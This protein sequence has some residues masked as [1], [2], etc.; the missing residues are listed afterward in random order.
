MSFTGTH[1]SHSFHVLSVAS[2]ALQQCGRAVV[3]ETASQAHADTMDAQMF[4]IWLL[5]KSL[6]A[7]GLH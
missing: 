7:Y 6:L 2:F 5:G 1:E 3:T 4:T